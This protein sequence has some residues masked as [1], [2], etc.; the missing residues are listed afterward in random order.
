[1][2]TRL[3]Q[4]AIVLLAVTI[5]ASFMTG[6]A[7]SNVVPPSS[8]A[9]K[10]SVPVPNDF[11]PASC[12]A[13]AVTTLVT[14]TGTFSGTAAS[15]LILGSAAADT[16]TSN[17]SNDC[18][19][20]G[21]GD[22]D[23]RAGTGGG[24]GGGTDVLN[25]GAGTDTCREEGGTPTVIS[26]ELTGPLAVQLIGGWLTGTTHAG[27]AGA[28]RALI[29]IAATEDTGPPTVSSVT[30]GGQA[31]TPVIGSG[32]AGSNPR[33][34]VEIWVLGEA[35]IA[36]AGS[37][38]FVPTWSAAPS[39]PMYSHAFFRNVKQA[40][41]TTSPQAANGSSGSP[42]TI[43]TSAVTT[44]SGDLA[45]FGA[46]SA[47]AITF[48]PTN[49]FTEGTDASSGGTTALESGYKPTTATSETPA[50]NT[51]ATPGRWA[52]AAAVLTSSTN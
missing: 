41:P 18:V 12:A 16:I 37:S 52:M 26:C 48:S 23:L 15:D 20:G 14:G 2:I 28:N 29:F 31:M 19:I 10:S 47:N 35:G 50:T 46:V 33:V 21:N 25:G 49:G 22:D 4:V 27:V 43:S 36:A 45:V 40:A 1:M 11:K 3:S 42:T 9:L 30:Y 34:R 32:A 7:A 5:G 17:A 44:I 51:D 24:A 13:I 39:E 8:A 6:W 38:T